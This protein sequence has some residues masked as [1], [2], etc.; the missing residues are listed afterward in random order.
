MTITNGY[1]TVPEFMS[2]SRLNDYDDNL[3]VELSISAASRNIERHTGRRFWQDGSVVVREYHADDAGLVYVDDISTTTGLI[4][5]TDTA[6]T[7]TFATTLTIN[8]DFL[9]YPLNAGDDTP[10]RPWTTIRI[11][12]GSGYWFPTDA[13]RPGVQVTAKF[14][15]AAVPDE[16]KL[17]CVFQ[18]Q[19]LYASKD[20]RGGVWGDSGLRV[21][22]FMHP[23]AEELLTDFV[24]EARPGAYHR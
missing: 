19:M 2:H 7:G 8:T 20:A 23:Q 14:G 12:G 24:R 16:V 11:A 4:V 15:W 10:A 3:L 5:K 18:A 17:A 9:L 22:R 13:D 21:S 6:G 1:C